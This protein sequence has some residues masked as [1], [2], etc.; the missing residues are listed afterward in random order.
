MVGSL[1]LVEL[2]AISH[3]RDGGQVGD[4]SNGVGH[5]AHIDCSSDLSGSVLAGEIGRT[6]CDVLFLLLGLSSDFK[7][8]HS[9]L[10]GAPVVHFVWS[11]LALMWVVECVECLVLSGI[12]CLFLVCFASQMSVVV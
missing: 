4:L 6:H 11:D 3:E 1:D 8:E 5:A 12:L 2:G 9:L 7:F 10:W